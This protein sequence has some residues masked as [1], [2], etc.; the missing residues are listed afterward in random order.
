MKQNKSRLST[1]PLPDFSLTHLEP[2]T[3]YS[4]QLMAENKLGP[5]PAITLLADTVRLAE[6]RTA[7]SK[8]ALQAD[9]DGSESDFMVIVIGVTSGLVVVICCVATT[10]IILL[11]QRRRQELAQDS[12]S[13][14]TNH[15]EIDSESEIVK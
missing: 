13:T 8:I 7:E 1:F 10:S 4:I 12:H 9:E 6:K 3:Q 11:S 15:T 5:G 14:A 2:G